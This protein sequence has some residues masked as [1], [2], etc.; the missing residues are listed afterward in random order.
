MKPAPET[1]DSL[2]LT[3]I[4]ASD[5]GALWVWV[6]GDDDVSE[7]V[8]DIKHHTAAGDLPGCAGACLLARLVRSK[9]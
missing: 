6:Y 2:T 8:A 9:P 5:K 4:S 7:V 1:S 3:V